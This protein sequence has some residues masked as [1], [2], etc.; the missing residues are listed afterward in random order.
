M[1]PSEQNGNG[2]IA[3]PANPTALDNMRK[4]VSAPQPTHASTPEKA[5]G[6]LAGTDALADDPISGV[7]NPRPVWANPYAKGALVLTGTG[8]AGLLVMSLSG[9]GNISQPTPPPA[10]API[11]TSE[12]D[13]SLNNP[14]TGKM[15]ADL[16]LA[17]Q[18]EQIN[19]LNTTPK[20]YSP[21]P[22]V[23]GT[24]RPGALPRPNRGATIT[25]LPASPSYRPASR[26]YAPPPQRF[27]VGLQ[28]AEDPQKAWDNLSGLGD[29]YFIPQ[30]RGTQVASAV[31]YSPTTSSSPSRSAP[32][33]IA[34]SK[35]I[36][37]HISNNGVL[38][39]TAAKALLETPVIFEAGTEG[40]SGDDRF[41]LRL[42]EDLLG[43]DKQPVIPSGSIVVAKIQNVSPNGLVRLSVESFIDSRTNL[44]IDVPP[45]AVV[46]R[47]NAG[48]PLFAHNI[49]D[50]GP[51]ISPLDLGLF[52]VA[53]A[54]K[55]GELINRPTSTAVSSGINGFSAS[56]TN[57]P[58]NILAGFLDGG[59][60]SLV[61][62]LSQRN[63][64][65]TRQIQS[66]PNVWMVSAGTV[67]QVVVNHSIPGF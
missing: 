65:A 50:R 4:L 49:N 23:G 14:E 34:E 18:S 9:I 35:V 12:V 22:S 15:K 61:S 5:T 66:R 11:T 26:T 10:S 62:I 3:S 53:G 44:Q 67:V 60:Q 40:I 24:F 2:N 36:Q 33:L 19:A 43:S 37:A 8:V 20:G 64:E 41:S 46:V 30:N 13:T 59:A 31:G 55:A 21:K 52:F 57:P 56:T 54:G 63:I 58:P 38:V 47:G 16:A 1:I 45:G 51:E 25:N 27:S 6:L 28:S 42:G 17:Q 32:D 48:T 29:A 7:Q 39:S